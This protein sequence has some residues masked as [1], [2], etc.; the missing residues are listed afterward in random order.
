MRRTLGIHPLECPVCHATMVLLAVITR[1]EVSRRTL[2]HAKVPSEP[3][4]NDDGPALH[5]HLTG[6]DVPCWAIGVDPDPD[7]RGPPVDYDLVD[8]AAPD[9]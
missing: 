5:Y 7:E 4:A 3:F 8:P 2:E 6:Q 9:M 1:Q